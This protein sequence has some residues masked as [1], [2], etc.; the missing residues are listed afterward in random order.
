DK[1][2]RLDLAEAIANP[3]N[4]LTARVIV[5]RVWHYHFGRGI[6][7]TTSNFGKLG[8]R[9]THPEL[10]DTL[11]VRFMGSG[12]SLRWLHR[13]I[14]LSASYQL[15]RPNMSSNSDIDPDTLYLWRYTPRRLDFEAWRDAWLAVSGR[16]DASRGGPS[17]DLSRPDNVRRTI[18]A[19]VSRLEP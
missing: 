19:K 11:A 7:G 10:L 16:L 6:V 5:N 15:A 18:Y 14:M 1:F 13:E 9:P 17:S 3:R 2:T 4:P 8:D 12:W